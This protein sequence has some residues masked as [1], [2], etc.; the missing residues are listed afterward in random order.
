MKYD[1]ETI[2][3]RQAAAHGVEKYVLMRDSKG[4]PPPEWVVPLSVADMEFKAAPCILEA[5]KAELDYGIL[6]YHEATD[7]FR[8]A[9]C[10]WMAKRHDWAIQPEW[11]IPFVQVI[12]ALYCAA[13]AFTQPGDGILIL[14]PGYPQFKNTVVNTGRTVLDSHLIPDENGHYTL[15]L[16]DF[17]EKAKQA[18]IFYLCSP[19]NPTGRVWT[20]EELRAM[21]DIC[22]EYGV[23]VVADE[24]H[25]DLIQPGFH[26]IPYAALGEEYANNCVI[27]TS[28]SKTFNLAGLCF[29]SII[30]SNEKIRKAVMKEMWIHAMT[31]FSRFGPVAHEAAYRHGADWLDELIEVIRGNFEYVRDF[32]TGHFPGVVVTP[33]EATYLMWCNFKC[34]GMDDT[35]LR[36][37]LTDDCQLYL[38]AG[39]NYGETGSGYQRINLACPRKILE[40]ALERLLAGAKKRGLI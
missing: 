2:F 25:H 11:I 10:G 32:L 34:F 28:L 9:C 29:S 8:E 16:E 4:N 40:D 19:Q 35:E 14:T 3:D 26:H 6:G 24:I 20:E 23:L 1:F 13:W 30:I 31:S 5:M 17:R 36:N 7:S 38:G 18:K 15:D 37:F 21:G 12:P 39:I 33:L 22:N 27:C